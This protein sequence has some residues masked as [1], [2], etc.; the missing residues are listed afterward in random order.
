MSLLYRVCSNLRDDPEALDRLATGEIFT[1]DQAKKDGLIDEIGF[2][3]DAIERVIELT[4]LDKDSVR[5]VSYKR[6][7]T[8]LETVGLSMETAVDPQTSLLEMT[9][10]RAYYMLTTVPGLTPRQ[11]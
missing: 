2:I 9:V 8:L 11:E 6:P 7:A 10:P 1:A 3:E 5:V 4:G